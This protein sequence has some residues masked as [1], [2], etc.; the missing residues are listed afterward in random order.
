M[1]NIV[2][3]VLCALV[4][5]GIVVFLSILGRHRFELNRASWMFIVGGFGLL[6]L[7]S[8]ADITDNFESLNRL[9]LVGDTQT[10]AVV[11][12]LAGF[13]GGFVLLAIGLVRWKSNVQVKSGE[14]AEPERATAELQDICDHERFEETFRTLDQRLKKRTVE[15]EREIAEHER[16]EAK[17]RESEERFKDFAEAT[18]DWFWEQDADLRFTAASSG[19]YEESGVSAAD[20]IGKT[21]RDIVSLGVSEE[22]W[23][24][25]EADLAARRPFRDFTFQRSDPSGKL[26]D[27]SVSGKPVFD[28]QGRFMGYRGTATNIT[29]RKQMEANLLA[30]KEQAEAANR[31]KSKFL[32]TMSHEIRTP[33][34]G[35]MGMLGLLL[36]T[37][38]DARQTELALTARSSAS[39]LLTILDDILDFSKL[40][41]GRIELERVSFNPET[42]LDSVVSLLRPQAEDKSLELVLEPA[43]YLP[44]WVEGDPTRWRQILVNLVGNAIKFTNTGFV[45]IAATHS[46]LGGD[47]LELRVSVS[48][49]GIGIPDEALKRL[50]TRFSQADSTTTRKFG[51]S[52]LGLAICKQLV[53][54]MGGEIGV[55]TVPGHGSTFWFTIRCNVG[56][57]PQS[58]QLG[59]IQ[60][61]QAGRHLQILVAED[62]LVNQVVVQSVLEAE[63]HSVH[64]VGNGREAVEA[65]NSANY[66]LVLMDVSMP[67]MDGTTATQIIRDMEGVISGI[68][69]IA[70]TAN[71]MAEH[72]EECRRA[73]MSDFVT[74]P[75][76]ASDLLAAIARAA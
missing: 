24:Q 12:K 45:R 40:E 3:E 36:G 51:G 27:F 16:T 52:G 8:L 2:L 9:V 28:A 75:F 55:D 76:E 60:A 29:D 66:D 49:S 42:I 71:A 67:E 69:I 48:D 39:G 56:A 44:S 23:R 68:P 25:H 20:H 1:V 50:F 37:N 73:G 21:R 59:K 26:Q 70:L 54:L 19:V 63:G 61:E 32:A 15:L 47:D 62:N 6:F 33:M 18:S 5:L 72:R 34:S 14:V 22:Q 46:A 17:L 41:E 11:E 31:A 13:L 35:V 43:C 4:L 10:E 74:K 7:G 65:V 53:E 30:A 57:P 58:S 64:M 38:L